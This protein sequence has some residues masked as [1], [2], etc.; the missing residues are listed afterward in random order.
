MFFH[1]LTEASLLRNFW[2]NCVEV[3]TATLAPWNSAAAMITYF[4]L[5]AL[6]STAWAFSPH[7][8]R[9]VRVPLQATSCIP[10]RIWPAQ[11]V[12]EGCVAESTKNTMTLLL[13]DIKKVFEAKN[14][15]T[16]TRGR[17]N[18]RTIIPTAWN[19]WI[20]NLLKTAPGLFGFDIAV[21]VPVSF[22]QEGEHTLLA[23]FCLH[24]KLVQNRCWRK[25]VDSVRGHR[26]G[27]NSPCPRTRAIYLDHSTGNLCHSS[28]VHRCTW[29]LLHSV[30]CTT[31]F[32]RTSRFRWHRHP[33]LNAQNQLLT[34]RSIDP[35]DPDTNPWETIPHPTQPKINT[36]NSNYFLDFSPHTMGTQFQ[37][38][39]V[40]VCPNKIFLCVLKCLWF[41][42]WEQ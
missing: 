19:I 30:G 34:T 25:L 9:L 27:Q 28:L 20:I 15:F 16:W 32:P 13:P 24:W 33:R 39:L 17:G 42:S 4:A 22:V 23:V 2:V 18:R 1:F 5:K 37:M 35:G 6:V 7:T 14:S 40:Q 29:L 8:A 41:L 36:G 10:F 26:T 11:S 3:K 21:V 12:K 38:N 31:Q